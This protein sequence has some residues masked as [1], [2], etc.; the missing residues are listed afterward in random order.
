M[1]VYVGLW[2]LLAISAFIN[3]KFKVP[4]K[5]FLWISF[6]AMTFVLGLRG[7]TVGE[8]TKMYLSVANAATRMSWKEVFA[9][10]PT[11]EWNFVSY[12]SYG[13][14]SEQVETIYMAYN[15]LIMSI[16]RNPQW[17]LI[18]TAA[19]T[20]YFMM[21]FIR[22]NV[23]QNSDFYLATYVYMCDSIYMS[24]FNIMRQALALSIA[25]QAIE[26][27]KQEKYKKAIMWVAIAACFH[28]SAL[29]FVTVLL[30]YKLKEKR[31][32]YKWVVVGTCILP[33]ALPLVT[34]IVSKILPKYA[35]YLQKSFW[36]AQAKGTLVLWGII[37]VAILIMLRHKDNDERTWWLIYMA[38]IYIGIELIGMRYTVISRIAMYF[39]IGLLL[40][41]PT[42]KK[43]FSVNSRLIYV[44]GI[45]FVM[46]WSFLSYASSAARLYA[47]GF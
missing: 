1:T 3:K 20:C 40:F 32:Y 4:P 41:F 34:T 28:L 9:S 36:N 22:N 5:C 21:R 10:F 24:S 37:I 44:G 46:T 2:L 27:V 13:G 35:S 11:T 47:F 30:I 8:D 39:R 33:V 16:F 42:M 18:I 31:K 26:A 25:A 12:G 7:A 38:T 23:E 43:Y 29:L 19:L 6:I 45:L 15:K 17:V 14:Y